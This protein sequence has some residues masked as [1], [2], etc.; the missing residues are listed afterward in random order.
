MDTSRFGSNNLVH[1]RPGHSG[2]EPVISTS[3]TGDL[4]DFPGYMVEKLLGQGGMGA[5]YQAQHLQLRRSVAIKILTGAQLDRF[6]K[7]AA[8][9]AALQHPH[10]VQLFD[11]NANAQPPYFSMELVTGGSLADYLKRQ[12]EQN[13][14]PRDYRPETALLYKLATA[15]MYVHS[16]GIVHRD[17][18]PA[19]ILLTEDG[20]PKISD[21][22]LAQHTLLSLDQTTANAVLGTPSYMSPEQAQGHAAQAGPATDIYSLGTMLY[23]LLVGYPPFKA[24]SA[25]DTM[26]LI[27]HE[28]PL[29]LRKK[30]PAIP[31]DLEV[32]CLKCLEKEPS[33][34]YT[35]AAALADD[36]E[37]FVNDRPI[38]ACPPGVVGKTLKLVRRNKLASTLVATMIALIVGT[39]IITTLL[40]QQAEQAYTEKALAHQQEKLAHQQTEQTLYFHRITLADRELQ[41]NRLTMAEQYLN[42][43]PPSL[44]HWEWH[45]L[46]RRCHTE[47]LT[48]H[49]HD[50][51]LR[52]VA[53]SPDG[54][55]IAS[56]SSGNNAL[57]MRDAATGQP[58]W[59]VP[60]SEGGE[61]NQVLFTHSSD[62]LIIATTQGTI[63][64]RNTKTGKLLQTVLQNAQP[65][66]SFSLSSNNQLLGISEGNRLHMFDLAN[67]RPVWTKTNQSGNLLAVSFHP[68]EPLVASGDANGFIKLWRTTNGEITKTIST[69]HRVIRSLAFSPDGKTLASSGDDTLIQLWDSKTGSPRQTLTGH[70]GGIWKVVFNRDNTTLIS[71]SEDS[72]LRVWNTSAAKVLLTLRGHHAGVNDTALHP[73]GHQLVSGSQDTTLK[74]WD[75]LNSYDTLVLKPDTVTVSLNFTDNNQYLVSQ[76]TDRMLRFWTVKT[77][78]PQKTLPDNTVFKNIT[79]ISA[80]SPDQKLLATAKPDRI[81]RIW[82][83][84]TG[85]EISLLIGHSDRITALTFSYDAQRLASGSRDRVVKVWD[86]KT[87]HEVLSLSDHA[88]TITALSFSSDNKRLASSSRDLII[89]LR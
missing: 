86:V 42:D 76:G 1:R 59:L 39:S 27:V 14:E 67:T 19:N 65:I 77:G 63:T 33:R 6:Y 89:R 30:D 79:K 49:G 43:C 68:I 15:M 8:A 61:V 69:H 2:T 80:A 38:L 85:Q 60:A 45:Y 17:L 37:R 82:N 74:T 84:D 53:W 64:V 5:V 34:R 10:V 70:T 35:T 26:Y 7:E 25:M 54:Q 87:G 83:A 28:E 16:K 41:S 9:I 32:I 18:K 21:F 58:K 55:L 57:I 56:A 88:D 11:I 22:G 44:R 46:K 23:E 4:P 47:L 20:E 3:L 81:I 72:S 13:Q 24:T 78:Q 31:C 48:H 62:K 50:G 40:W 12:P 71:A 36:L 75:V 29:A 51:P 73:S 66:A 52:S